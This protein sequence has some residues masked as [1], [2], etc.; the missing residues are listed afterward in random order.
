MVIFTLLMQRPYLDQIKERTAKAP[1]LYHV[2][3]LLQHQHPWASEAELIDWEPNG[4]LRAEK[5]VSANDLRAAVRDSTFQP[6]LRYLILENVSPDLVEVVGSEYDIDQ[7]FWVDHA[8]E[9][10]PNQRVS[11]MLQSVATEAPFFHVDYARN[12]RTVDLHL[13]DDDDDD[14]DDDQVE[15]HRSELKAYLGAGRPHYFRREFNIRPDMQGFQ[16]RERVSVYVKSLGQDRWLATT[17]QSRILPTEG[18]LGLREQ[19][20]HHLKRG[21]PLSPLVGHPL[22]SAL[23]VFMYVALV[24]KD[25]LNR[26]RIMLEREALIGV[27]PLGPGLQVLERLH[28]ARVNLNYAIT[29]IKNAII[30]LGHRGAYPWPTLGISARPE[31]ELAVKIQALELDF[32]QLLAEA[33]GL[34][35]LVQQSFNTLMSTLSF[36]E[37]QSS[38]KTGE[39][40][41]QQSTSMARLTVLAFVYV[42]LGFVCGVFGMN[43]QEINGTGDPLWVFFVVLVSLVVAT[44]VVAVMFS[45]LSSQSVRTK[46]AEAWRRGKLRRM[47]HA[48]KK[49][50]EV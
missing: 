21:N 41:L 35:V 50:P 32:R 22:S 1:H 11:S 49:Y 17:W 28:E 13:F 2:L 5:Y 16:L 10:R 9:C 39:V 8:L 23:L 29:A 15:K 6:A 18:G 31:P 25:I 38:A 33:E 12:H 47:R 45:K 26:L 48:D 20:A 42:P 44:L 7:E 46:L 43:I 40:A 24:W 27:N 3:H 14:D 37:T 4:I 30:Y 19:L 34:G 36:Q